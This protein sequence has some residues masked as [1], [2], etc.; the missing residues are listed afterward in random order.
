MLRPPDKNIKKICYYFLL[1]VNVIVSFSLKLHEFQKL[2][3]FSLH[4]N[5]ADAAA[6]RPPLPIFVPFCISDNSFPPK[7][8]DLDGLF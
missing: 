6:L 4:Y 1:Q 2:S 7:N 8:D 5:Y 3:S